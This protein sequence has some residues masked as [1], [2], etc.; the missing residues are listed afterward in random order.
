MPLV[1]KPTYPYTDFPSVDDMMSLFCGRSVS[2]STE[3]RINSVEF[4]EL[5]YLYLRISCHNIYPISHVHIVSIDRC[6]FL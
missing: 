3:P 6:A 1:C 4:I 2:R 5:N